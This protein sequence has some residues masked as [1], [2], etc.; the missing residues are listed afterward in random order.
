MRAADL[1]E[2]GEEIAEATELASETL[3][4][5]AAQMANDSIAEVVQGKDSG[6]GLQ[7]RQ[8]G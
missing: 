2:V 7:V 8:K 5:R 3:K 6:R 1:A 4:W